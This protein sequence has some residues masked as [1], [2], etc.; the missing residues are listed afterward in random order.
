MDPKLA[1]HARRAAE[2]ARHTLE[3]IAV[4]RFSDDQARHW[5]E[6]RSVQTV[7]IDLLD[8]KAL[9]RLPD[10]SAVIYLVGRKFGTAL[11][12]ARTW[13]INTLVPAYVAERFAGARMVLLSTGNVY[14]LVPVA[15]PA[16]VETDELT[17]AGEYANA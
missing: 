7:S 11:D 17:P 1:W 5:L 12:A 16:S 2:A 10:A 8:R 14:P 9:K 3:I 13:A 6:A 15:G 4:S